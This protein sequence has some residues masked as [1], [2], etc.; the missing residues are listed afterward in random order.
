M[1]SLVAALAVASLLVAGSAFASEDLAKE[2]NCTTCHQMDANGMGP[3]MK[4]I[5]EKYKGQDDAV[6]TL[7]KSIK[8]GSKG[9]YE[10]TTMPAMPAQQVSDD[11]AK[12]LA[13]WIVGMAK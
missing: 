1:K 2:K 3:G 12:T 6:A 9:K 8:E 4:Q 10:G 13:E 5:A 11:E 7:V